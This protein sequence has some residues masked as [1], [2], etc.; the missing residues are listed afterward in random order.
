MPIFLRVNKS[1]L[2]LALFFIVP[3]TR[4]ETTLLQDSISKI[5]EN[6]TLRNYGTGWDC[7]SGYREDNNTCEAIVIPENQIILIFFSSVCFV[8]LA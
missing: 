8:M 2:L 1:L 3:A 4:S 6:A 7:N 5:P